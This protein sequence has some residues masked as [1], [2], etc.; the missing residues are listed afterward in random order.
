MR[1]DRGERRDERRSGG[2]LSVFSFFFPHDSYS[3]A[4][5]LR[6]PL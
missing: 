5:R 6:L 3:S 1:E 2:V 4:S